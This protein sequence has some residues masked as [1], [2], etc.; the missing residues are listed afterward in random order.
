[1]KLRRRRRINVLVGRIESRASKRVAESW[2]PEADDP[3]PNGGSTARK[4]T[5]AGKAATRA[6]RA[7]RATLHGVGRGRGSPSAGRAMMPS[8]R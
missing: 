3:M 8:G 6:T 1:V 5:I 2:G 4:G 7:T